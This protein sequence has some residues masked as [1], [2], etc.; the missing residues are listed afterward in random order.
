MIRS[1]RAP[2]DVTAK[3]GAIDGC[4]GVRCFDTTCR[5]QGCFHFFAKCYFPHLMLLISSPSL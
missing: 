1:G 4:G 2:I 5:R 3:I